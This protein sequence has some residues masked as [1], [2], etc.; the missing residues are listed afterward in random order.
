MYANVS[1]S[2]KVKQYSPNLFFFSENTM[3]KIALSLV[4]VI[5]VDLPFYTIV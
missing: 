4:S 3:L 1:V 5:K 2:L